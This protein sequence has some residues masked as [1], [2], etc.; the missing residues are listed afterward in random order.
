MQEHYGGGETYT[1]SLCRAAQSLGMPQLLIH[2]PKAQFWHQCIHQTTPTRALGHATEIASYLAEYSEQSVHILAHTRLPSSFVQHCRSRG[3]RTHALTHMPQQ[4]RNVTGLA[5]YDQVYGVSHYVIRSLREQGLQNVYAEP[6]YGIAQVTPATATDPVTDNNTASIVTPASPYDWDTRKWRDRCLATLEQVYPFYQHWH[7]AQSAPAPI[8]LG[9]VSRLTPI[10]QFPQL[11]QILSPVLQKYPA[12]GLDIYGA[13]GYASV[14]DLRQALAPIQN[15]VRWFGFQSKVAAAYQQIDY[16]MT[17]LPEKEALGLN[18]LEAAAL[19]VPTLAIQA[20]PFT[21]TI[22]NDVTGLF[23]QDPR[24]D[25]GQSFAVL[26]SRLQQ[27]A[28]QAQAESAQAWLAQFSPAEF[29]ARWQ[30][31]LAVSAA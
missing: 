31:A 17:G 19:G 3:W 7:R 5:E 6:M 24:Q 14:R 30:R 12:F 23:Y 27:R 9:I 28:F 25:Q 10:K 22:Q 11:F 18:V 29:C 26:L 15:R 1:A 4:G 16:L 20:E 2:H 8:R 13:G 21:E